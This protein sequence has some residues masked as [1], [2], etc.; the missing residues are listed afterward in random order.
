MFKLIIDT[1]FDFHKV[2]T[3]AVHQHNSHLILTD[4]IPLD[5][6]QPAPGTAG[7]NKSATLFHR[8][9]AS[10]QFMCIIQVQSCAIH[11]RVG[12]SKMWWVVKRSWW[13]FLWPCWGHDGES[14]PYDWSFVM[15]IYLWSVDSSP[16]GPG[17][18]IFDISTSQ[19]FPYFQ[20]PLFR[21]RSWNNGTRC[22]SFLYHY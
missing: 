8:N 17:M 14:F 19:Y 4:F 11:H 15:E 18:R 2:Y 1:R 3:G 6:Y 5:P 22:M 12:I 21:V 20:M 13:N 10:R 16:M 9:S 7:N